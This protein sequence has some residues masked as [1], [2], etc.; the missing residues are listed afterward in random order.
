M[1]IAHRINL[2][3]TQS[4]TAKIYQEQLSKE[5]AAER[6]ALG[7]KTARKDDDDNEGSGGSSTGETSERKVS[8]TDPDS[9]L[10]VKGEHE[11]RF[12]YEAHTACDRI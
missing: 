5:V 10:F 9:G 7:K 1:H 12:A 6:E 4:K 2:L 11:K 8:T 3:C